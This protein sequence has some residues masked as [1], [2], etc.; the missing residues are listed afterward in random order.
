MPVAPRVPWPVKV[1]IHRLGASQVGF[2]LA[3]CRVKAAPEITGSPSYVMELL[4]IIIYDQPSVACTHAQF[5]KR[6]HSN[7]L[8]VS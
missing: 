5:V 6:L 7:K 1:R 4:L 8:V 3:R 2:V